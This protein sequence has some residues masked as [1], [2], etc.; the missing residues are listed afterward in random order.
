MYALHNRE[1]S[2][3]AHVPRLRRAAEYGPP[4]NLRWG[5]APCLRPPNSLDF[6][7]TPKCLQDCLQSVL[8]AAAMLL[9][10]RRKYDH[11]APLLRDG[12]HWLK[13]PLRIEF[14]ICL[15]VYKSLHGARAGLTICAMAWCPRRRGPPAASS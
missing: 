3:S 15:L 11:V 1:L 4:L 9:C 2:P 5:D 8:N 14:K 6:G 10:N 7:H 12:L 13:V